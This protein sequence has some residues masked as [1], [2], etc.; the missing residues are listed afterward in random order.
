[1]SHSKIK[2]GGHG[3]SG[4]GNDFKPTKTPAPS[5][6]APQPQQIN[7]LLNRGVG[8]AI[9]K[10]DFGSDSQTWTPGSTIVSL[11]SRSSSGRKPDTGGDT[12][13][14]PTSGG[15]RKRDD[16]TDPNAETNDK[17]KKKKR[18]EED[19]S[20]QTGGAGSP[21]GPGGSTPEDAIMN[22]VMQRAIQRQTQT[23][24]KMQD[25]MKIKDDDD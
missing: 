21:A 7:D 6:P 20:G 15:K 23:R 1:M 16:E 25:A 18:D 22:I 10:T 13:P 8:N 12:K 5:T 17:K 9:N 19:N 3:S 2:L 4:I 11:K 14:D 24:Q